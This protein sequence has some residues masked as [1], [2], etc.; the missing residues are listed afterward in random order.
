[1]IKTTH[2][3][4]SPS[5]LEQFSLCSGSY[6]MQQGI[7]D[8][9]NE[10]A[11]EGTMLHEKVATANLDGLTIEQTTVV[12]RCLEYLQNICKKIEI[13]EIKFEEFIEIKDDNN[14]IVTEG[15]CD[16]IIID[17]KNAGH[18][19]DWKFGYN[20][21]NDVSK[22]PQLASYCLGVMQKYNLI[23]CT[24]YVYQPRINN[25]SSYTFTQSKA[26][27][28][29]IQRIISACKD[30]DDLK[31]SPST[32]ACRYCRARLLC[33]AFRRT[34]QNFAC[35]DKE[36]LTNV[37]MLEKLYYESKN[38]SSFIKKIE[39]EVKKVIDETG[40]CGKYGYLI[41]DGKRQIEDLNAL[42]STIKDLVTPKEFNSICSVTLGELETL[43]VDKIIAS[44]SLTGE[45]LTKVDA[46]KEV[47]SM[48]ESLITRGTPAKKII[49]ME[50][51]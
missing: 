15:T 51:A 35:V 9:P 36:Y 39:N 16:V 50:V 4:F 18:V 6:F 8:T 21:V 42:Y 45:T 25:K 28:G 43:L 31:L 46:K 27:L 29:Y 26:I 33:P 40:R 17:N 7:E 41:T 38:I 37:G 5:K 1:M 24:G 47:N 20:A 3:E 12:N 32:E 19:M 2:H 30:T 23:E 34:F 14:N 48:L 44:R 49:E 11:Q 22:N 13:K 10:F